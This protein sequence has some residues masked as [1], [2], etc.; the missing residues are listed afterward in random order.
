MSWHF[1]MHGRLRV[2]KRCVLLS[3]GRLY[4]GYEWWLLLLALHSLE[5]LGEERREVG[6]GIFEI[7]NE[8]VLHVNLFVE[9][10]ALVRHVLLQLGFPSLDVLNG[11][12]H[13]KFLTD[14]ILDFGLPPA[15][16]ILKVG[17]PMA[18]MVP[19][20]M[21]F[22]CRPWILTLIAWSLP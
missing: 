22:I 21:F 18:E 15:L 2:S 14:I 9:F 12:L 10:F 6:E 8:L 20:N 19:C 16:L 3:C 11:H 17:S 1:F 5:Q 4:P 7:L 13:I